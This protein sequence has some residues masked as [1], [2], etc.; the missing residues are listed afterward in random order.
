MKQLFNSLAEECKEGQCLDTQ[1][2]AMSVLAM[3]ASY[4]DNLPVFFECRVLEVLSFGLGSLDDEV[5]EHA[6]ALLVQLC[7]DEDSKRRR[8]VVDALVVHMVSVLDSPRSLENR[9]SKRLVGTAFCMLSSTRG[10]FEGQI[11]EERKKTLSK[12]AKNYAHDL[13]LQA[14][15]AAAMKAIEG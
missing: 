7:A 14:S 2:Q 12:Y 1:R 10:I 9:A 4:P 15:M 13:S 3:M 11:N 6:C 8:D 5:V